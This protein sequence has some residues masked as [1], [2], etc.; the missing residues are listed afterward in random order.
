MNLPKRALLL[1]S[2]SLVLLAG[3]S[4]SGEVVDRKLERVTAGLTEEE[5]QTKAVGARVAA[6]MEALKA[7]DPERARRHIARALEIDPDS[8]EAHNAMALYY[9]FEGDVKREEDHYR[10]AIRSNGKFSQARNN[11]AVLLYR[12]GRYKDAIE[13]LEIAADDTNYDQ[14]HM[15]WLNLGRSY[16]A[17]QQYDKAINAFQR[18]LRLDSTQPDGL[19]ELADAYLAQGQ[20]GDARTYHAAYA[21]RTRQNARS[22]WIGIRIEKA[23]GGEDKLASYE[24][25][26]AKMYRDSPE[27]AA[28]QA[29]KGNGSPMPAAAS[30]GV[31]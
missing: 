24:F 19:L 13:Q 17:V 9:R 8:A 7:R 26:L 21:A 23:L 18:S 20:Y 14:R 10:K 5:Q 2:L 15:A 30:K 4:S 25:Q 3:C 12:Q 29:W 31:N 6:G 28:W 16:A 27:Y 22:L 11:F 1:L